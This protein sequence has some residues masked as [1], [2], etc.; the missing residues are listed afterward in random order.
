MHDIVRAGAGAMAGAGAG[1]GGELPGIREMLVAADRERAL[2]APRQESDRRVGDVLLQ[3]QQNQELLG[4][5]IDL[6][7]RERN[8]VAMHEGGADLVR[9]NTCAVMQSL[10][11]RISALVPG[12]GTCP[13]PSVCIVD[14]GLVLEIQT[15]SIKIS[16]LL[17]RASEERRL[18]FLIE[19]EEKLKWLSE[20]EIGLDMI[21]DKGRCDY[22]SEHGRLTSEQKHIVLNSFYSE[23]LLVSYMSLIRLAA[24]LDRASLPEIRALFPQRENIEL[25]ASSYLEEVRS[26]LTPLIKKVTDPMSEELLR[27]IEDRQKTDPEIK[28]PFDLKWDRN[29]FA[30]DFSRPIFESGKK[31]ATR[32]R[33]SA[34]SFEPDENIYNVYLAH[35]LDCGYFKHSDRRWDRI[36]RETSFDILF[37][38]PDGTEI[39]YG[40]DHS[41]IY[42]GSEPDLSKPIIFWLVNISSA[43]NSYHNALETIRY[44]GDGERK[45]M[46]VDSRLAESRETIRESEELFSRAAEL[47]KAKFNEIRARAKV[48]LDEDEEYKDAQRRLRLKAAGILDLARYYQM[49]ISDLDFELNILDPNEPFLSLLEFTVSEDRRFDIW[50]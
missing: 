1:A 18:E 43:W 5:A 22:F 16:R 21:I 30:V 40:Y 13:A 39:V 33:C 20:H 12:G 4:G 44:Y 37:H 27:Q 3:L 9:R 25:L 29:F 49:E 48:V 6:L 10:V 47:N 46:G 14:S 41:R 45:G 11:Q 31:M 24:P 17:S 8:Q 42:D 26:T 50:Q 36:K 19:V 2:A 23:Q 38:F 34:Q 15:L 28:Y 35:A 32:Y 7:N